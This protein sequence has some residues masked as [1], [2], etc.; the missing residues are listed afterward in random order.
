MG[1][2]AAMESLFDFSAR[3]F[4]LCDIPEDTLIFFAVTTVSEFEWGSHGPTDLRE[5]DGSRV[6]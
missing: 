1:L 2:A 6:V 4:I 5:P 3:A